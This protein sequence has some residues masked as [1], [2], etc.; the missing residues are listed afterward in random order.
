MGTG[1]VAVVLAAPAAA[2]VAPRGLALLNEK[3]QALTF[4]AAAGNQRAQFVVVVRNDSDRVGQLVVRYLGAGAPTAGLTAVAPA[5]ATTPTSSRFVLVRRGDAAIGTH[6][7]ARVRLELRRRAAKPAV[8]GVLVISLD[9]APAAAPV[10]VS[11]ADAKAPDAPVGFEQKQVALKVTR[12]WG[13]FVGVCGRLLAWAGDCPLQRL[14]RTSTRAAARGV[15][16]RSTLLTSG[17]G[18]TL[19]LKAT[20][21]AGSTDP[22][23]AKLEVVDVPRPGKYTGQF[24]IDPTAK[25]PKAAE[26]TV[27]VQD[28]LIWPLLAVLLGALVGGVLV[29]RYD[30]YRG[31]KLLRASLEDAVEP[32]RNE[33]RRANDVEEEFRRP[34]RFYLVNAVP[35]SGRVYPRWRRTPRREERLVPK[36]YRQT[37]AIG[38]NAQLASTAVAVKRLAD[39][40]A[41]WQQLNAAYHALVAR[42]KTPPQGTSPAPAGT[43]IRSDADF[44]L[45]MT[46]VEPADDDEAK[47]LAE[48]LSEQ[49]AVVEIYAAAKAKVPS[50]AW[51]T[52]YAIADPDAIYAQAPA[53]EARTLAGWHA[54]RYELLRA[55]R[56]LAHPQGVAAIQRECAAGSNKGLD[57]ILIG[58]RFGIEPL[59]PLRRFGRAAVLHFETPEQIRRVVRRWDWAVFA[60]VS[61]LTALAYLLPFYT[62]KDYGSL[63]DY[64]TAF[65]AGAIVPTAISWALLPFARPQTVEPAPATSQ[66]KEEDD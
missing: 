53:V 40:F 20:P 61:A 13:P 27:D 44:L 1:L 41:R 55:L 63:E 60:L 36:L 52:Q 21:V 45:D 26:V 23:E 32:Y 51:A 38:D 46:A 12:R 50:P 31:G 30:V 17:S 65:A 29:K 33:K 22:P 56:L 58:E 11:L 47:L 18:D 57:Q 24:V 42:L 5:D 4:A 15:S 64:L 59:E 16:S 14:S 34:G 2:A 6:D 37:Y 9:S 49:A 10:T 7:V 43:K 19:T 3:T 54:L 39:R 66:K 35:E 62:G 8:D 28:S 25:E 48:R